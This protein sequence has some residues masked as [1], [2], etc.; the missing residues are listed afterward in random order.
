MSVKKAVRISFAFV[1]ITVG[2]FTAVSPIP[3]G[4]LVFPIGLSI[5]ICESHRA[6]RVVKY[7]RARFPMLNNAMHWVSERTGKKVG[8]ALKLTS[9]D[10]A[11]S[12][13]ADDQ[14]AD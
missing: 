7:S 4:S 3:G 14:A 5:L 8:D 10:E 9:P 13:A 12:P 11:D 1:L 6:R 2:P